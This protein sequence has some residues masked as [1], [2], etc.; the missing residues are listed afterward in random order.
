MITIVVG[1]NGMEW[2]VCPFRVVDSPKNSDSYVRDENEE[3]IVLF[4]VTQRLFRD[5]HADNDE[6]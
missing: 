4:N 6:D 2:K 5:E 3:E 1:W